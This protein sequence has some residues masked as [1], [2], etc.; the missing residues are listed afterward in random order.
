MT[1]RQRRVRMTLPTITVLDVLANS[2]GENIH[3][4][5]ICSRAHLGTGTVYPMLSRLEKAGLV[6]ARWEDDQTWQEAA[7]EEWRPRRRYYE[8]TGAGKVALTE[9]QQK[10]KFRARTAQAEDV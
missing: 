5:E 4:L 7:N 10:P 8:I 9:S 2:A 3:G 6:S 1:S